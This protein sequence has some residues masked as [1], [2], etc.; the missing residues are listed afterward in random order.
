MASHYGAVPTRSCCGAFRDALMDCWLR[1]RAGS[2]VRCCCCCPLK[3][4]TKSR[5]LAYAQAHC[6]YVD[7]DAAVEN[8]AAVEVERAALPP[9]ARGAIR[10][11]VASDTHSRHIDLGV[12]PH[13]DLFVHCGDILMSARLW[14]DAGQ[15]DKLRAFNAWLG[16]PA[17]PCATKVVIMGNHDSVAPKLGKEQLAA[18]LTNATYLENDLLGEGGGG[19]GKGGCLTGCSGLRIF[20]T[21]LSRGRS[22]NAAYQDDAFAAA[23]EAAAANVAE[24][25]DI[26]ITHGPSQSNITSN[27]TPGE[28]ESWARHLRPRLHLWGHAHELHGVRIDDE[29]VSVC[30]SI[31]DIRY[32]AEQLAVVVD[33]TPR[34]GGGG[35]GG[36]DAGVLVGG[37]EEKNGTGDGTRR[38]GSSNRA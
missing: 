21:P 18:V 22:G 37:E 19:E 17:V 20:A 10:I 38:R 29:V 26:F 25:V 9:K 28:L 4:P 5:A 34:G 23:T 6:L 8:R 36:C 3:V 16:S 35:G 12:L 13:G 1:C 15:V 7:A 11:V 32:R 33:L 24:P 31:S 27:S 14:T 30:A 2:G